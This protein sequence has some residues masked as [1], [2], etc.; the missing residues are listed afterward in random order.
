[1]EAYGKIAIHLEELLADRKISK[2]KFSELAHM[3]RTQ[4][5]NYCKN[6]LTRFD[7]DVLARMCTV[8]NCQPGDILTFV[9]FSPQEDSE[10][11]KR[12]K[13]ALSPLFCPN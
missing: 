9:P 2:K 8:L 5:N 12:R 13:H 1:M 6:R 11:K 4:I 7:A 3:Q 10:Q